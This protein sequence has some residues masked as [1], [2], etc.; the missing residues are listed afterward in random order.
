MHIPSM[1]LYF[2]IVSSFTIAS[3]GGSL[4]RQQIDVNATNLNVTAPGNSVLAAL[5]TEALQ[6]VESNSR[7]R[8]HISLR[9]IYVG[10]VNPT[11]M[12][13]H[14]SDMRSFHCHFH[15]DGQGDRNGVHI[16]HYTWGWV[17]PVLFRLAETE[18]HYEELQWPELQSL[19]S[20][21]EADQLMTA[22][23]YTD[24]IDGVAMH[25]LPGDKLGYFYVFDD[26]GPGPG[27]PRESVFLNVVTREITSVYQET[28]RSSSVAIS[29]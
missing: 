5:I 10:T 4:L 9:E 11:H 24:R 6:I 7:F 16:A 29:K 20:I 21:E 13:T 19:V 2:L 15:Y 23:G 3:N 27:P 1:V 12:A 8:G 18:D 14:L 26:G 22:A 17:G 28:T 25:R